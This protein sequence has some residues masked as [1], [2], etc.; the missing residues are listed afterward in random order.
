[1]TTSFNMIESVCDYEFDESF[2]ENWMLD[3]VFT[4]H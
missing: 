4:F 2:S 1:M 3:V